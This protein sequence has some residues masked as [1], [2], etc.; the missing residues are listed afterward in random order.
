M[1]LLDR[2]GVP[3]DDAAP[4][5][6]VSTPCGLAGLT[7]AGATAAVKTTAAVARILAREAGVGQPA[8]EER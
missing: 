6:A 8:E 3:L 7:P 2:I 5:L 4:R 1:R